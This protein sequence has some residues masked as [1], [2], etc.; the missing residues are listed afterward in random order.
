MYLTLTFYFEV[1]TTI[2]IEILGFPVS[3]HLYNS[4]DTLLI[5]L[6]DRMNMWQQVIFQLDFA[7]NWN[8]IYVS[9]DIHKHAAFK[10]G[11]VSFGRADDT[12]FLTSLYTFN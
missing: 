6:Y 4:F 7:E 9:L 11:W 12:H 2:M 1:V 5:C 3:Q 8:S 10:F